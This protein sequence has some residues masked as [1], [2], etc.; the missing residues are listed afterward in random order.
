MF[1]PVGGQSVLCLVDV[2]GLNDKLVSH[3]GSRLEKSRR[4][5]E[6]DG[7]TTAVSEEPAENQAGQ[8]PT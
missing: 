8:L 3:A 5:K 4:G 6:K 1:R 2:V 7:Q